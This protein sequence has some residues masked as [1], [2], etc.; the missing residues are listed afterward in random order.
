MLRAFKID[1][2]EI[3]DHILRTLELLKLTRTN[4]LTITLCML[5]AFKIDAC[6]FADHIVCML[7]APKIDALK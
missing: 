6:E 4:S 2:C 3:A 5:R 1:A 7:R